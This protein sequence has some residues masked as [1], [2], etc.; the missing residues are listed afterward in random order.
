LLDSGDVFQRGRIPL[1]FPYKHL[2]AGADP[3]QRIA[4]FVR[5]ACGY[6]RDRSQP[7]GL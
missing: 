4:T 1:Q 6:L 3:L 5:Q 7:F 2:G